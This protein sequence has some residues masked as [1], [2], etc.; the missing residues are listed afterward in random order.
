MLIVAN[1][2]QLARR[3]HLQAA[4]KERHLKAAA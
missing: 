4:R 2:V 3:G 1:Y